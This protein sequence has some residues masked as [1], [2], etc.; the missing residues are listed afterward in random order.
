MVETKD[1]LLEPEFIKKLQRLQVLTKKTFTGRMKGERRSKKKGIS[2]E[3]ADYRRYV[4]G[5]DIRFIDWNIYSRLETLFLKLFMEEE[6]LYLYIF[7]D[8][9]KSMDFGEPS[10]LLFAKQTA[11]ALGYIA[12]SNLDKVGVGAFGSGI[13]EYLKPIRGK[14]NTFKLLDF[15]SS[16]ETQNETHLA[17]SFREFILQSSPRGIAVLI[18]DF[19]DPQG[20]EDAINMFVQRNFEIYVIHVLS[21]EEVDPKLIGHLELVDSE[22]DTKTYV[23]VSRDLIKKYQDNL[24]KFCTS[25]RRYCIKRNITYVRM[26]NTASIEELI[27]NYLK[28]RGL[29][30]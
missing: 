17:D 27:M 18:S 25:L 23:S 14:Q 11:A 9:S 16:V 1:I 8:A 20:F 10:K 15:L 24:N 2:T 29:I 7:V 5:D 6:D 30:K 13:D 28:Y 3:F 21:E 22:F 12:L 19:M 4:K 26:L